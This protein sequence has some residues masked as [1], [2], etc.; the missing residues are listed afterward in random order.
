VI[1][2]ADDESPVDLQKRIVDEAAISDG[3]GAMSV[4]TVRF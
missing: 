3:L 2:A 1:E 4:E